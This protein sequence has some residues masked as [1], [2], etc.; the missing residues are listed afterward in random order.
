MNINYAMIGYRIRTNRMRLGM[1]Q[2]ELAEQADLSVP[3]L[4]AIEN[5]RKKPSLSSLM[6]VSD[7]MSLS[8]DDLIKGTIEKDS[9]DF[10][11]SA[12]LSGC[13]DKEKR[14]MSELLQYSQAL[15][16]RYYPW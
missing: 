2:Q 3:Y 12:F 5:A 1:S 11:I 6:F 13:S 8:L 4:S 7:A 15:L 14:F 16:H 10:D 9:E